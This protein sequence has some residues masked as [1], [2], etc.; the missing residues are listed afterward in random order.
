MTGVNYK[1]IRHYAPGIRTKQTRLDPDISAFLFKAGVRV[2]S[3]T[4]RLIA[5]LSVK[6][7]MPSAS[8]DSD[9]KKRGLQSARSSKLVNDRG[10]VYDPNGKKEP[11]TYLKL[12][13]TEPEQYSGFSSRCKSFS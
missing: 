8:G 10:M 4:E 5:D 1:K 3:S 12:H 6:A 7:A 9:G 11:G 13:V 2:T